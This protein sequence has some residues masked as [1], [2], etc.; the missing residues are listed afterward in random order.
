MSEVTIKHAHLHAKCVCHRDL[1]L[2]NVLLMKNSRD[3]LFKITGFGLSKYFSSLVVLI[4]CDIYTKQEMEYCTLAWNKHT[5][6]KHGQ[7]KISP[8]KHAWNK[9]AGKE[10]TLLMLHVFSHEFQILIT[11]TPTNPQTH[12]P[13]YVYRSKDINIIKKILFSAKGGGEGGTPSRKI[14]PK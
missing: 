6:D 9:H 13:L 12:I 10:H 11:H 2:E 4:H 5:Q 1:K 3:S 7:N 14:L 8:N